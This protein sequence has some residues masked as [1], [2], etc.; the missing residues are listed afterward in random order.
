MNKKEENNE[1]DQGKMKENMLAR[2]LLETTQKTMTQPHSDQFNHIQQ[3]NQQLW[4][5]YIDKI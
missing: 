2:A 4:E 3:W 5:S 1:R